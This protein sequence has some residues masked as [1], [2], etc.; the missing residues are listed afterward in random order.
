MTREEW[1]QE[2]N[3]SGLNSTDG[4]ERISQ[5]SGDDIWKM[6]NGPELD[7]FWNGQYTVGGVRIQGYRKAFLSGVT[8]SSA[9]WT[10]LARDQEVAAARSFVQGWAVAKDMTE[11]EFV[12]LHFEDIPQ[13]FATI[14]DLN[15]PVSDLL[16]EVRRGVGPTRTRGQGD[17]RRPDPRHLPSGSPKERDTRNPSCL[18]PP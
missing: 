18:L 17:E 10:R 6:A 13:H 2:I 9:P 16:P 8:G 11:E 15:V 5:K 14:H 7:E 4:V 12:K 3:R 1:W